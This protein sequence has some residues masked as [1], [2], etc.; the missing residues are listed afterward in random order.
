ME[1]IRG[2]RKLDDTVRARTTKDLAAQIRQLPVVP[3][4]LRLAGALANLSTEGDFGRDTLQEV[5]TTLAQALREQ[6][7]MGKPG[8]PDDLYMELASLVRYEHMEAESD[9]PQFAEAF[10]Q[11]EADDSERQ[12]GRLYAFGSAGEVLASARA[13][14][15]SRAGEFLGDVVPAVPQGDA[16]S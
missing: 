10:A 16:G 9:N 15:Q 11:L 6:P 7:P 2:L 4:K 8:E 3:N 12:R 14:R 1:Q 5:T 13:E